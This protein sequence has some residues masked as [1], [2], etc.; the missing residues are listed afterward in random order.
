M[1]MGPLSRPLRPL[2]IAVR[3]ARL[4]PSLALTSLTADS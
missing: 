1:L 4:I 2:R 3:W